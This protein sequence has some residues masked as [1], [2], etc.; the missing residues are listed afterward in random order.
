MNRL[1]FFIILLL[2]NFQ[3]KAQ[4]SPITL[5]I[6]VYLEGAY[7]PVNQKMHT[8]LNDGG[9][10]PGQIP[11]T[12]FGSS[13]RPCHPYNKAPWN[14]YGHEGS[15]MDAEISGQDRFA[16]YPSGATDYVLLSLRSEV[17]LPSEVCKMASVVMSD[18]QLL[19]FEE[20][21][22]CE[23]DVDSSYYIVIEHKNHLPVMSHRPINFVN[24][25]LTYDFR[26][27]DSY[28]NLFGK[29]QSEVAPGVFAMLAG[30]GEQSNARSSAVDINVRDYSFWTQN[31]GE[32]SSYFSAD[33]DLNGD[34]N[35]QDQ[36]LALRNNGYLTDVEVK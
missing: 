34:V 20:S 26:F 5:D 24:R 21:S 10:L 17:S 22:C 28:K 2:S 29:G 13:T 27:Q 19:F 1:F 32:N 11:T 30:N 25:L 4:S 12:F 35:V 15:D 36:I 3:L 6:H 23:V 33:Y 14:Y 18:G 8:K 31:L 16:G 7:E 9:Y